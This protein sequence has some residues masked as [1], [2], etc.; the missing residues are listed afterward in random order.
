MQKPIPFIFVHKGDSYYLQYTFN[1]L[2]QSNPQSEIYLLGDEANKRYSKLG[3][4]HFNMSDYGETATAFERVYV[5]LSANQ[6]FV[7]KICFQRWMYIRDFIKAQG[8]QGP[9]C[10]MD[11]DVLVYENI[12]D[13]YYRYC[14]GYDV[15]LHGPYGPGSN[16]FRDVQVLDGLVEHTFR[17]YSTPELLEQLRDR[18]TREHKNVTDMHM[19]D[20]YVRTQHVKVYDLLQIVDGATFDSHIAKTSD[21]RFVMDGQYKKVQY[22]DGHM[23][24]FRIEDNQPVMM[25]MLHIQGYHKQIM[26]RYFHGN[27]AAVEARIVAVTRMLSL[28]VKRRLSLIR[29]KCLR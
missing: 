23:Y 11:S 24:C 29:N 4:R 5:H 9:F 21:S 6:G 7:E 27:K 3:I 19:I 10:C 12:S 13:Y 15:T 26:Y 16:V 8:I 18:Y 17:S 14:T 1:Q 2:K 22:K 20:T 28:V 25:Y